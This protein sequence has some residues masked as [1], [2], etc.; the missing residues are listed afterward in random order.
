MPIQAEVVITRK[1][2]ETR[3]NNNNPTTQ[4]AHLEQLTQLVK[5]RSVNFTYVG[6][7]T[8]PHMAPA[9]PDKVWD[10]MLPCFLYKKIE[11]NVGTI[12]VIHFDLAF[13]RNIPY[14][15]SYFAQ[16]ELGLTYSQEGEL[17]IWRN[18]RVE[19]IVCIQFFEDDKS[20]DYLF[21]KSICD[22]TLSTEGHLV[23]QQFTGHDTASLFRKLYSVAYDPTEFK[24]RIL[25]DITYGEACHCMT[26]MSKYFPI[27]DSH[28]NFFNFQLYTDTEM[29][30][31]IGRN[32][33]FDKL[34]RNHYIKLYKSTL[35]TYHVDYRKRLR[36]EKE[37]FG[38]DVPYDDSTSPDIIM[39]FLQTA[40]YREL[41]ILNRVMKIDMEQIQTLFDNYMEYDVYKWYDL[42]NK[43]VSFPPLHLL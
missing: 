41:D 20:D 1:K 35:N 40:L 31:Y 36:G 33:G 28:G 21:I 37:M 7:G 10:Q 2:F 24:K 15:H 3:K 13:E 12:R 6:I 38:K 23:L 11:E 42:M 4:M 5:N 22:N 27:Y 16:S 14:L 32:S 34:I 26:N 18:P 39:A 43:A 9:I 30:E 17:H 25:F 29:V 19:I 8:C